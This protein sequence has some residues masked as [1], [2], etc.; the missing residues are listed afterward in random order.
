MS[1]GAHQTTSSSME[2]VAAQRPEEVRA[3]NLKNEPS[4]AHSSRAVAA[5]PQSA[6]RADSSSIEEEPG[7]KIFEMEH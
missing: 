5:P 2:E 7:A 3:P 1:V 4:R 6:L